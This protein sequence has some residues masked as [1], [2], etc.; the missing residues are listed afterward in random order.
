MFHVCFD[1][2]VVYGVDDVCGL[3]CGLVCVLEWCL[4]LSLCVAGYLIMCCS[5]YVGYCHFCPISVG[6]C[7][8]LF[9]Q[10]YECGVLCYLQFV[11]VCGG[12]YW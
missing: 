4:F 1:L 12:C 6:C 2:F 5:G 8:L 10:F 11:N 3:V 7:R 9:I